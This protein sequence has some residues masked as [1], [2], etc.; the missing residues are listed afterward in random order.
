MQCQPPSGRVAPDTTKEANMTVG[1]KPTTLSEIAD[2]EE[3]RIG[4][5][6]TGG[7]YNRWTPIWVVRVGDDLYV[8][9]GFGTNGFWYR[10]ATESQAYVNAAGTLYKVSLILQTDPVT[11]AAVDKAYRQKYSADS[12]LPLLLSDRARSTTS[13]LIPQT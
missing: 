8:R 11:I 13:R 9:S 7:G 6:R 1:W 10:H 3:I 5:E 4:S 2:Q 12:S